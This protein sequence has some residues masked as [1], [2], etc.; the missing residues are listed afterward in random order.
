MCSPAAGGVF[1]S[2]LNGLK[3][4]GTVALNVG[5]TIGKGAVIA[6]KAIP[7]LATPVATGMGLFSMGKMLLS[8][9]KSK[10]NDYSAVTSRATSALSQ[11]TSTI[12]QTAKTATTIKPTSA[13]QLRR[14]LGSLRIPQNSTNKNDTTGINTANSLLGLNLGG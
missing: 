11:P 13:S 7:Q 8:S 10:N 6:A 4:V 14:T 5:K 12:D 1:T 9:D 2:L 3:T